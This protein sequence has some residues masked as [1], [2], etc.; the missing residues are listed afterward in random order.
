[1]AMDNSL[2]LIS[3]GRGLFGGMI[4]ERISTT[5]H[6]IRFPEPNKH[7]EATKIS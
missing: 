2:A 6:Q 4:A 1:M 3:E 5:V 7:A